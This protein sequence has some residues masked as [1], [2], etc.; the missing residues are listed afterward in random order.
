MKYKLQWKSIVVIITLASTYILLVSNNEK[1]VVSNE[2]FILSKDN[3][4]L[5]LNYHRVRP[6]NKVIKTLDKIYTSYK[7]NNEIQL[8][9][10]YVDE[11][12]EQILFLKNRGFEF[13]TPS[14]LN[15][16]ISEEVSFPQKCALITFDD[17][18]I[19]VYEKAF[20]ILLEHQIPFSLFIVT[21]DVGNPDF[22]GLKMASWEQI[23]EMHQ[24]GL[25]TIGGHTHKMH[26]LEKNQ[27]APFLNPKNISSF[28]LDTILLKETF[29]EKL[30]F[31]PIYYAYPYGYGMPETDEY[32]V[33]AGFKLIFTLKPGIVQSG[34]S[35][36][37]IKRILITRYNWP[38][39]ESWA[40]G[41]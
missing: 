39:V 17:V 3:G 30:G 37:Y 18:D 36:Y 26:F 21:G 14:Q 20:P 38:T 28:V 24:S 22:K 11:F 34:D 31:T 2:H 27:N 6:S 33:S 35:P 7:R 9:S 4:C 23:K 16:F 12:E 15:Q 40:E 25:A 8:Y 41:L 13:I 5:V 32:L 19:S 1:Y 10:V 29:K